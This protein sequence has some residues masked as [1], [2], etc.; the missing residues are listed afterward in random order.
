[1]TMNLI[2]GIGK[3]VFYLSILFFGLLFG[4]AVIVGGIK[5]I[6]TLFRIG[7]AN[8]VDVADIRPESV[9]KVKGEVQLNNDG[10]DVE[11]VFSNSGDQC[12]YSDWGLS[13]GRMTGAADS[14]DYVDEKVESVPFVLRG[15]YNNVSVELSNADDVMLQKFEEPVLYFDM[16]EAPVNFRQWF[17]D[18]DHSTKT[19]KFRCEQTNLKVGDKITVVG[20]V[21]ESGSDSYTRYV[22]D[23]TPDGVKTPFVVTD[24]G[25]NKMKVMYVFW[26]LSVLYGFIVTLSFGGLFVSYFYEFPYDVFSVFGVILAL[27]V[28]AIYIHMDGFLEWYHSR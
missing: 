1:M 6:I 17:S 12:V 4:L 24:A 21:V 15:S 25:S 9:V 10:D 7:R 3:E 26:L 20:Y 2:I 28:G 5:K 11:L 27:F 22:I 14:W 18:S 19:E 8:E 16:D 13:T 23:S